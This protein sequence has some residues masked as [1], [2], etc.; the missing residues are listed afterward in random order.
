MNRFVKFSLR[1]LYSNRHLFNAEPVL[2]EQKEN[3]EEEFNVL[4]DL[5]DVKTQELSHLEWIKEHEAILSKT[6]GSYWLG[7]TCVTL[8][9]ILA[10]SF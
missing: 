7:K 5:Q 3:R 6:D 8:L 10:F 9:F 2:K 4:T 1:Q